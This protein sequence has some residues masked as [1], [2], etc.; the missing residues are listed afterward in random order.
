MYHNNTLLKY[1]SK[2]EADMQLISFNV[3][4]SQI[5]SL[6]ANIS[7]KYSN[8]KTIYCYNFNTI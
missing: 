2:Y 5:F 8:L 4:L 3:C 6:G 1:D 7:Y